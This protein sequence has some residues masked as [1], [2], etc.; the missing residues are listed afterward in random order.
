MTQELNDYIPSVFHSS[1]S[2]PG[3]PN[4]GGIHSASQ[5]PLDLPD[6]T[7]TS[8]PHHCLPHLKHSGDQKVRKCHPMVLPHPS[9]TPPSPPPSDT[10]KTQ[11]HPRGSNGR[12]KTAAR[13]GRHV[14][15]R[16]RVRES[17]WHAPGPSVN[18]G[19]GVSNSGKEEEGQE[20]T[21]CQSAAFIPSSAPD[22]N[23]GAALQAVT[24]GRRRGVVT[25]KASDAGLSLPNGQAASC[26]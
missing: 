13:V 5:S 11:T 10:K 15:V 23:G 4:Q 18:W 2:L 22:R 16:V 19:T 21:V 14:R 20:V 9:F 12:T 26:Y 17:V 1:A 25:V 6:L 24:F 8:P 7:T 3:L